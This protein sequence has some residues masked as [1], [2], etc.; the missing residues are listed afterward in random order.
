[1]KSIQRTFIPGSKWVYIKLYL[2]SNTADKVLTQHVSYIVNELKKKQIIEKWFFIR[3][4]DP[5]FHLRIRFLVR[6]ELW[7][8]DILNLFYKRLSPLVKDN[9]IWKIQLDTYN[10]ELERYGNKLIELAESIFYYDSECILSI[11]KKV[12]SE[13]HRWMIALRMIDTLL[14]DFSF[15]MNTK[16]DIMDKISNSFKREFGFN[17]YNAK[18]FN[19]KYRGN[20]KNIEETLNDTIGDIKFKALYLPIQKK[21]KNSKLV[22]EK[23]NTMK[24]EE[25]DNLISSY[26]HMTLN[27]LFQ[28]KNRIHELV[29]YDFMKRYYISEIAKNK[30]KIQ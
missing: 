22:I 26:I 7:I 18:Q 25:K 14:S 24:K 13:T 5:D 27:R 10:R 3:Y 19:S 28:S 8:G 30:Y 12:K 2:G 9:L 23:L 21:S 29:L 6:D 1:M 20:K 4:T 16:K 15:D 17:E 11:L